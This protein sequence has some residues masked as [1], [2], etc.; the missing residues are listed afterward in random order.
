MTPAQSRTPAGRSRGPQANTQG[1]RSGT[2][3]G[4]E[5]GVVTLVGAI[6]ATDLAVRQTS[7]GHWITGCPCCGSTSG[8][9]IDVAPH[10]DPPHR[11]IP[12]LRCC[13]CGVNG[14]AVC[15][16]LDLP[17]SLLMN[18][19]S[20]YAQKPPPRVAPLPS[21]SD[22]RAWCRALWAGQ[23]DDPHRLY[24][25]QRRRVSRRILSRWRVGWDPQ[26]ETYTLPV[27]DVDGAVV[28][29]RRY[30]PDPPEDVPKMAGLAGRSIQ[31][32]PSVPSGWVLLVEGEWDALVGRSHGLP[33]VTSTGGVQGWKA[34][35]DDLFYKR[36]VAICFDSDK[37][38]REGAAKLARGLRTIAS[39]LR[40]I[41][42]TPD[43][44][45][46]YDLTDWFRD[47]RTAGELRNL[48]N[49]LPSLGR[50][51]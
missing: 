42:L 40:V 35:W 30:R 28:N 32:Y 45:D 36:K 48:I 5:P 13:T 34:G 29:L 27:F 50:A 46:G 1:K 49:G 24:L 25:S 20:V 14:G 31:L 22:V 10:I 33:T 39:E 37:P 26:R 8:L 23:P 18:D 44:S 7:F 15:E 38:G 43:R 11:M 12:K 47:G 19:H 6:D 41:D 3:N 51:R 9:H 16:A 17:L 21:P 4:T 2:T